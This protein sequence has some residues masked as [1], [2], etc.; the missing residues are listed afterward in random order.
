MIKNANISFIRNNNNIQ[1]FPLTFQIATI[2]ASKFNDE[3]SNNLSDEELAKKNLYYDGIINKIN[4]SHYFI[5]NQLD[6][7]EFL[8]QYMCSTVSI[9]LNIFLLYFT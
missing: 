3:N 8:K 6:C 9:I 1:M 5:Y 2:M 7:L 4:G